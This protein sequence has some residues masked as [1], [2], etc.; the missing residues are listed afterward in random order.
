MTNLNELAQ[1][2]HQNAKDKGFWDAPRNT[3]EIFMLIIS[4]LAEALEADRKEDFAS[5]SG[6]EKEKVR[7]ADSGYNEISAFKKAFEEYVKNTVEDEIADTAIRILDYC[8]YNAI[9]VDLEHFEQLGDFQ[10]EF[11]SF[12]D[13]LMMVNVFLCRACACQK[14]IDFV[15]NE[16]EIMGRLSNINGALVLLFNLAKSKGFDL[17]QHIELKMKYNATREHKNGKAY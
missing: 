16:T 2:I 3:G 5:I 17:M 15:E 4:E 8:A 11:D 9:T 7:I 13:I 12:G 1:Q 14:S 6:L 10:I